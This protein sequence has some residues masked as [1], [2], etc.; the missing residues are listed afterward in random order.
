MKPCWQTGKTLC[1]NSQS[2][3]IYKSPY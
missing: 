1:S 3:S 2:F